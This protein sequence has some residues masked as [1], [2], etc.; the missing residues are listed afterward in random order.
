MGA[1][2]T[3]R[4]PTGQVRYIRVVGLGD[5]TTAGT[6][7]WRSPLEAPPAGS[8]NER[9]QYAY[10]LAQAHPEWVIL[11]RGVN[12]ERADQIRAR[13]VRDVVDAKADVVIVI[14]GVNDIYQGRM[15]QA[16]EE[17]LSAVYQAARSAGIVVVAGSILPYNSATSDQNAAMA[18]VNHWIREYAE[19]HE[20]IAFCD[21]RAAVAAPGAPDR[22]A[23]SPDGLH[24]D[25][26]GY[27]L[28]A[29]ALDPVLRRLLERK[30]VPEVG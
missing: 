4:Y 21:T 28:M 7:G 15:A 1:Q 20:G 25:A 14:A 16:V 12:G 2:F 17:E 19:A 27:R 8:G 23:G 18:A 29:L 11:N 24:P 10:W 26:E 6:P 3:S 22:L 9:S 13:F 5:S 30:S